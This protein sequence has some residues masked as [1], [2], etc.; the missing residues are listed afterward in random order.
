MT[1]IILESSANN[2]RD[3]D[4]VELGK[5]LTYTRKT[6]SS[7]TPECTRRLLE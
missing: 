6:R 5:S 3:D 7:K 2:N 4:V 1:F